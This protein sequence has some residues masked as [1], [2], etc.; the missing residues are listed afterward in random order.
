LTLVSVQSVEALIMRDP[1]PAEGN[2][3][4]WPL[5]LRQWLKDPGDAAGHYQSRNWCTTREHLPG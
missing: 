2:M 5:L 3:P 1:L 4:V